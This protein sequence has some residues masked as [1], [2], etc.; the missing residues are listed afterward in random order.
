M[1]KFKKKEKTL[2]VTIFIVSVIMALVTLLE[3]HIFNIPEGY[4]NKIWF[5]N[6]MLSFLI[7]FVSVR[8][9]I[10]SLKEEYEEKIQA[11]EEGFPTEEEVIIY[12]DELKKIDEQ[13][14]GEEAFNKIREFVVK[15]RTE[16]TLNRIQSGIKKENE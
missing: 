7:Y 10:K 11:L 8:S 15:K 3:L 6:I 13:Y 16:L 1:E 9:R 2:L 14:S 4:G 5:G 12:K